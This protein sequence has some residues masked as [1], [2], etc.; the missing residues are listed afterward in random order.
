MAGSDSN[1]VV[2]AFTEDQVE[3]LTTLTKSML[4]YWSKIGFFKPQ[5][6]ADAARS[7]YA[8]IY[9]FKD[10]VGLRT[11]ALLKGQHGVSLRELQRVAAELTQYSANPWAD[12]TLYVWNRKVQFDEPDTGRMRGVTDKQYFMF[13][14]KS[15]MEDV[16]RDFAAM[17]R[18]SADDIGRTEKHRYVSHNAEVIAGTRIPVSTIQHFI[19]DKFSNAEILK[20][21]PT[22]TADDVEVVRSRIVGAAA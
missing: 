20:E 15:V 16:T 12:I 13:P 11:I 21:Y 4:R 5:L 19:E 2:T 14:L 22:L 10:V 6:A 3:R 7:P 8:R 18:R 17:R 9:S 1:V